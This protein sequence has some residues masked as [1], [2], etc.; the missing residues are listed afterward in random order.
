V[1]AVLSSD[2]PISESSSD[3]LNRKRLVDRL[4]RWVHEAPL[5]DGF[6]IGLTGPWGSGKTSILSLLESELVPETKVIWFEPW[7]FSAADELV[8]RFFEEIAAQMTR[9]RMSGS[10]WNFGGGPHGLMVTR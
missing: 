5:D 10:S 1:S 7:L 3:L 9:A 6:V 2:R 8:P 4:A